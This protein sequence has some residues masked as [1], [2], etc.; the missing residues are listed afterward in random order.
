DDG[1]IETSRVC[2]ATNLPACRTCWPSTTQPCG[3]SEI[4]LS[5][6]P[7]VWQYADTEVRVAVISRLLGSAPL[8]S[9]SILLT[10]LS[11]FFSSC[12]VKSL[13]LVSPPVLMTWEAEQPLNNIAAIAIATAPVRFIVVLSETECWVS[14]YTTEVVFKRPV[15]WEG[16]RR[17]ARCAR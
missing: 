14:L 1:A 4:L 7:T 12:E 9:L 13:H 15:R 2:R 11:C 3:A 10:S 17:K 8:L 5:G 6:L 16:G